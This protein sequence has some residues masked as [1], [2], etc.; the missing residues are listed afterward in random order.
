[1]PITPAKL[2]FTKQIKTKGAE[3]NFTRV[4][5]SHV[6]PNTP[7]KR[8]EEKSPHA[9][10]AYEDVVQT[11]RTHIRIQQKGTLRIV[12]WQSKIGDFETKN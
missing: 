2:S 7:A 3:F 8:T 10:I 11:L 4:L 1:M 12:P 9:V 6:S 5:S